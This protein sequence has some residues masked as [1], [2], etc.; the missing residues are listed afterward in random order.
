MQYYRIP[1]PLMSCG[2]IVPARSLQQQ[3]QAVFLGRGSFSY[4]GP[5]I[6]PLPQKGPIYYVNADSPDHTEK[7][8]NKTA[9]RRLADFQKAGYG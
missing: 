1:R 7:C 3:K 5:Q 4:P 2:E 8:E 9:G 6:G